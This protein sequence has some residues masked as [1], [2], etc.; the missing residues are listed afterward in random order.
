MTF[1]PFPSFQLHL[2]RHRLLQLHGS[3]RLWNVRKVRLALLVVLQVVNV[4]LWDQIVNWRLICQIPADLLNGSHHA[5][6]VQSREFPQLLIGPRN[7]GVVVLVGISE[8]IEQIGVLGHILQ[9][10]RLDIHTVV[11]STDSNV[12]HANHIPD[13]VDV[14][15]DVIDCGTGGGNEGRIEVHHHYSLVLALQRDLGGLER[16]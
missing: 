16:R 2:V 4:L 5:E 13:V 3:I 7:E 6:G 10:H 12:V 11:V 9:A 15:H 1:F 8:Q 14:P